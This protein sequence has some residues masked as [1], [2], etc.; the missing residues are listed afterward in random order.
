MPGVKVLRHSFGMEEQE[1]GEIEITDNIWLMTI[2]DDARARET[3]S[4]VP[5]G[6]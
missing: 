5:R 1:S 3:P 4:S 2:D 6:C